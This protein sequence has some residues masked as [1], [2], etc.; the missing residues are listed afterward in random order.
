MYNREFSDTLYP[1]EKPVLS[2][3]E[4]NQEG[5]LLVGVLEN[6]IEKVRPCDDV[7][8][9]KI[10]G[11]SSLTR[12]PVDM[13]VLSKKITVPNAAPYTVDLGYH[14]LVAGQIYIAGL[15]L[16]VAAAPGVYAIDIVTG[17]LTFDV[18]QK[19]LTYTVFFKRNLTVEEYRA[20][21]REGFIG[22]AASFQVYGTCGVYMGSGKMFTDRFDVSKDYSTGV[23][24]TGA[25]GMITIGGAGTAIPNCTVIATPTLD[26]PWLGVRFNF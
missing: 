5:L 25:D 22:N 3:F 2:G 9:E 10:V 6:G 23:L 7:A 12:V 11:F 8:N 18:A 24:T 19:G 16:G 13:E 17:I 14:N 21:Y 20:K 26:Q 15:T 4:V 1:Q